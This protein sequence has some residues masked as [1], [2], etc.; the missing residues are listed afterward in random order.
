MNSKKT[1][2]EIYKYRKYDAIIMPQVISIK[3]FYTS[4]RASFFYFFQTYFR[5]AQGEFKQPIKQLQAVP[6]SVLKLNNPSSRQNPRLLIKKSNVNGITF[7]LCLF[8]FFFFLEKQ[9]KAL[10]T[11]S[12]K[13][14]S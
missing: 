1:I 5:I 10:T 2:F 9:G 6:I 7:F 12:I 14:L 3:T 4:K 13:S 11:V 8:T